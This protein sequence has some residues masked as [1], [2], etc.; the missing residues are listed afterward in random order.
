MKITLGSKTLLEKLQ[1]LSGVITSK[2]TL[3]ILENF[4]FEI[5]LDKLKITASDLE[6]TMSTSLDIVSDEA[7]SISVPAKMLLEILKAFPDQPL[8]L[9]ILKNNTIEINSLSG[10]YAIAYEKGDA[11]P[12]PQTLQNPSTTIIP[13]KVLATALSKTIFATGN[14]DLR[15]VMCGVFFQFLPDV[16]NFVSTD[17]HKLVKYSRSDIK[18]NASSEFII[19]KKPL[20]VL[21]SIMAGSS[22]DVTIEFNHSNVKFTFDDYVLNCR[23]IDGK[24]PNYEGVIP[25][26]NPNIMTI[27]RLL[28]LNSVKCVS[29]FSNK[30]THQVRL[31]ITGKGLN[32]SA[33]DVDYSN[34]GDERLL[35][36]YIGQDIMIGFNAK[37][38]TE[39]L[40][41]LNCETVQ[42]EMSVPNR[43][44]IL[45]PV[46]GLEDGE[47]VLMLLMPSLIS[48]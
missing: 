15:P 28:L 9:E 32:I 4:L 38:L 6:T 33:G 14:D 13:A 40:S 12:K 26:E 21:K 46:D 48:K 22:G 37:F 41:N 2:T 47:K 10:N 29:I 42:I 44:G 17:A 24:Y 19:P 8:T 34:K 3:P 31:K 25:K 43:A 27:D 23:L 7:G 36:N 20:T 39:M 11:F 5:D 30:Q 16:V 35:C 18:S 45:T 1:S